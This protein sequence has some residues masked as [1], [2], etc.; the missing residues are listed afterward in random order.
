[1]TRPTE[2]TDLET[3]LIAGLAITADKLTTAALDLKD[4]TRFT[5][6][7]RV[8]TVVGMVLLVGL[9]VIAWQNRENGKAVRRNTAS[10]SACTPRVSGDV[11]PIRRGEP[12]CVFCELRVQHR[13]QHGRTP[14]TPCRPCM[15]SAHRACDGARYWCACWHRDC[16]G[17][18]L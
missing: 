1:V 18:A 2:P 6:T 9:T 12:P 4:A 8:V 15:D 16:I 7:M 3:A 10:I 5:R 14:S 11:E 17:A 13:H